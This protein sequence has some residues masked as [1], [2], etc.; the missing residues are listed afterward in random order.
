MYRKG[1]SAI[2]LNN[3][4]Q[5][6]LVNLMSFDKKYFAIPGGGVEKGESIE[7]AVY[8]E[9]KEELGI[10]K[11]LLNLVGKSNK[12]IKYKFR[13]IRLER[14]G[15]KYIG[16]ERYFFGFN[17]LGDNSNINPSFDEVRAYKW[18]SYDD[19]GKYL[20]FEKQLEETNKKIL[21]IFPNLFL[22]V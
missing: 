19:L 17:F 20:L 13:E 7:Q 4:N 11:N 6:L 1:V 12:P 22:H 9:I 16:S 15:T 5:L 10:S 2:I 14:D 8:R 3:K 21:E 18:V